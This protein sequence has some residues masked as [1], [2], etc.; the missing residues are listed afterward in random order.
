MTTPTFVGGATPGAVVVV[1]A[2]PT[3]SSASPISIATG[4]A[5]DAGAWTATVFGSSLPQG[6]Y[7]ITA[8]STNASGNASLGLGTVVI[9][10]TAPVIT[11]VVFNRLRG[12]LDVDFQ[13]NL[14]GM[15]LPALANGASYQISARPLNNT[16]P[17]RNVI[18]PTGVTVSPGATPTSV[19]EAVIVF[20]HGKMLN[21][22]HYTV[23]V[24][25][26]GLFDVA[27]NQ[28]A[29]RFYGSYPTGNGA[30]TPTTSP[31]SA[32]S[33]VGPSPPSRSRPATPVPGT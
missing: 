2:V 14:S 1:Y 6:S 9:D 10:T 4:V 7:Q 8:K 31:S 13:D 3:G 5:N 22:G 23:Q 27:G 33:S 24:L 11:S 19:N 17:V 25:A 28:L 32:R 26:S 18:L 16:T 30:P 21:P 20:N 29:G 15:F 12:E